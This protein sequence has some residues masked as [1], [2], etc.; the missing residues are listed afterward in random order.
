[1]ARTTKPVF[2]V[3]TGQTFPSAS[4]AAKALGI[5]PGNLYSV[6]AG[7]RKTAGGYKFGYAANRAVS[8]SK[9]G[10]TKIYSSVEAAAKAVHA[11]VS[12]VD[13]LVSVGINKTVKGYEFSYVDASRV[14]SGANVVSSSAPAPNPKNRKS[15]KAAQIKAHRAK[16]QQKQQRTA[17]REAKRQAERDERSESQRKEQKE[18]AEYRK[19]KK[20]L[21]NKGLAKFGESY[22][23]YAKARSNL[24]DYMH[25]VNEQIDKYIEI[26]PALL[27]Y[28]QAT[29]AVMGLQ[30]YTGYETGAYDIT[31]FEED[32]Q[33][34]DLPEDL[35]E[36][37]PD[38]LQKM[39][40][41]MDLLAQRMQAEAEQKGRSFFDVNLAEQN[42]TDLAFEFY[43]VTGHE[44]D[45]D[46]YAYMIWDILDIIQRANQ[47]EEIGSDLIFNVVSDAMKGGIDHNTLETFIGHIDNWMSSGGDQ[48]ELDEILSELDGTY[49]APRGFSVFDDDWGWTI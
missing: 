43:K 9:N 37:S 46:E 3:G 23:N 28:N 34:F 29:P 14:S 47:Y 33:K 13:R 44:N 35:S 30:M 7:R 36:L 24:K 42:R 49:D 38:D 4:A 12:K 1:M 32:L 26:N 40:D 20:E 10:E 16:K 2:I 25:K 11:N 41:K 27:Y 8:V 22:F 21:A 31:Y 39:A 48:D 15:N 19:I 5:N 45:M 18:R 17:E 6:L